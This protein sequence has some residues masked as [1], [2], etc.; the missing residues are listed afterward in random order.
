VEFCIVLKKPCKICFSGQSEPPAGFSS[1]YR[2]IK[3]KFGYVVRMSVIHVL[4][5]GDENGTLQQGD[6]DA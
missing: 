3:L 1:V 2:W 5:G 4:N 6:I